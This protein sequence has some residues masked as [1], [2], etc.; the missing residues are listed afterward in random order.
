LA[1]KVALP[2]NL[3][4]YGVVFADQIKSL[5][6]RARKAEFICRAPVEVLADVQ[7]KIRVLIE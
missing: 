7:A 4:V 1:F 5:D 2:K 6:W 3:V